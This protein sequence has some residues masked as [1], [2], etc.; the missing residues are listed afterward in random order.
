MSILII[1]P[2]ILDSFQDLGRFGYSHWGINPGGAADPIAFQLA[3]ALV[4]NPQ[5]AAVLECHFPAPQIL[6]EKDCLISI[7]GANFT[8]NVDGTPISMNKPVFLRARQVLHFESPV[9]GARTYVAVHGGFKLEKWLDSYSTLLKAKVGGFQG[10]SLVKMD[11]IEFKESV[12]NCPEMDC[13]HPI[14]ELAWK[15][16]DVSFYKESNVLS[17]V[18]GREANKVLDFQTKI[19]QPYKIKTNSDRMALNLEGDALQLTEPVEMLST[20]VQ[21][22]TL[23]LLPSGAL[24]ILNADHQT[25]GGYPRVGH[26]IKAHWNKLG[27]ITPRSTLHFKLVSLYEAENSYIEQQKELKG[28]VDQCIE[29]INQW[30]KK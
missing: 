3:N 21:R 23:Q 18:A 17:I 4:G 10:R 14:K 30:I 22:G 27:Q 28:I 16:D 6:I 8:P 25:T 7:T 20:G 29:R 2:G 11:R 9:F 13:H 1:K 26:V 19:S 24:L 12:L 15:V 5:E